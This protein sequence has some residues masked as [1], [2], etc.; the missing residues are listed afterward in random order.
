MRFECCQG[1]TVGGELYVADFVQEWRLEIC[2][3]EVFSIAVLLPCVFRLEGSRLVDGAGLL[4]G[5]V[6]ACFTL[7]LLTA[8]LSTM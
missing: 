7:L 1:R 5:R 6:L 8:V 4:A 3:A 2:E